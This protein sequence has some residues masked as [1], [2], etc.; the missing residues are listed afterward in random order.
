MYQNSIYCILNLF[1]QHPL[2]ALDKDGLKIKSIN[3]Y[4]DI[5]RE[6]KS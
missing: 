4:I 6:K 5:G 3:V 1:D 2:N